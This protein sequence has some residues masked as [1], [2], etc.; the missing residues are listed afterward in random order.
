MRPLA[1]HHVTL[2]VADVDAAVEFYTKVLGLTER[3]DRPKFGEP[4]VVWLDAGRQQLHLVER[5]TT[6]AFGQHFALLVADISAAIEDVRSHGVEV[7]EPNG[8]G[9]ALQ[10]F[11]N[12]PWGNTI[13]LQQV[14]GLRDEVPT[15]RYSSRARATEP[16]A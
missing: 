1:I 16:A 5:E 8:V 14:K 3:I 13:E 7:R 12:D 2:N 9:E 4:R 6:P 11:L 10:T 15:S